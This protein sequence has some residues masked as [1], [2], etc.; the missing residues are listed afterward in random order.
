[1]EGH[2]RV[3]LTWDFS[4]RLTWDFAGRSNLAFLCPRECKFFLLPLSNVFLKKCP[5]LRVFL[6]EPG[7]CFRATEGGLGKTIDSGG[8]T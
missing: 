7:E 5:S 3:G 6:P 1:M 8:L 4:G 2:D